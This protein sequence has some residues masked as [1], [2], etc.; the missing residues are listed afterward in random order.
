[1]QDAHEREQSARGVEIEFHLALE[2]LH[3]NVRALVMQPAAR[4]VERLDAI[5]RR[6]ADRRVIAVADG[7]IVLDQP[8][9]RR[10]R[11]EMRN[12]R[13]TV[14]TPDVEHQAASGDA[15]MQRK[16]ALVTGNRRK[17]VLLEEIVNRHCA[18]MLHV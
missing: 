2:A 3:Q 12:D 8:S 14:G 5:R 11:E 16:R 13:R 18:L 1:M 15:Q 4:H 6:G 7:V 17:G 9:Q 10:E